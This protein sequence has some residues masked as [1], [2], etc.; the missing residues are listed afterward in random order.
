MPL[1]P[2]APNPWRGQ[3]GSPCVYRMANSWCCQV[4]P[5]LC[6]RCCDVPRCLTP[7][8]RL[9]VLSA[10]IVAL[11]PLFRKETEKSMCVCVCMSSWRSCEPCTEGEGKGVT[12]RYANVRDCVCM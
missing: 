11:A 2:F 4:R 12:R 7:S 10:S 5:L 1:H 6:L 8:P 9:L 3:R